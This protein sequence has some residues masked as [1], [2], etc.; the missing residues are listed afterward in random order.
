MKKRLEKD[1]IE[2]SGGEYQKMGMAEEETREEL[3]K[4]KGEYFELYSL[5]AGFVLS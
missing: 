1:G 5:Q 3:L 2:R 4:Q